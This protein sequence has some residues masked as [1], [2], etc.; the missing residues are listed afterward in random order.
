VFGYKFADGAVEYGV[1]V[2]GWRGWSGAATFESG[3]LITKTDQVGAVYVLDDEGYVN[4]AKFDI[5]GQGY[6]YTGSETGKMR[7]FGEARWG[8]YTSQ[9]GVTGA[10]VTTVSWSS[11]TAR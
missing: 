4:T 10:M 6:T 7:N 9:G 11:V 8:N 5:V 2:E 1:I 3:K